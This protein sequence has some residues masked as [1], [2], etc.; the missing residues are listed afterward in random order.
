MDTPAFPTFLCMTQ[1]TWALPAW[2][3]LLQE[4]FSGPAI[5]MSS[6]LLLFHKPYAV[7]S[8]TYNRGHSAWELLDF[9]LCLPWRGVKFPS[10][11]GA[12]ANFSLSVQHSAQDLIIVDTQWILLN[13]LISLAPFHP[14]PAVSSTLAWPRGQ[15]L[16]PSGRGWAKAFAQFYLAGLNSLQLPVPASFSPSGAKRAPHL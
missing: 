16:Q 2:P 15:A 14:E 5:S 8:V 9:C 7:V 10:D 6:L 11:T 13:K 12:G 3:A 1:W 4:A